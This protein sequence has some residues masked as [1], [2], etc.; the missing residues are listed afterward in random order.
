MNSV[1]HDALRRECR[2]VVAPR[3]SL[4]LWD[5]RM[6]HATAAKLA[7]SDTREVVYTGF[8]PDVPLN[9]AYCAQQLAAIRQNRPPPAYA[10]TATETSDR[11]WEET[12]LTPAQA[13]LLGVE[14]K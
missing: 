3:G 12:Q 4:V 5:N 2:P 13:R 11:N 8:L 7:G 1:Q 14:D 6:P 9:R 10:E